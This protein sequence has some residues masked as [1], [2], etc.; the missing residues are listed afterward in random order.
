MQ[1]PTEIRNW[2]SLNAVASIVIGNDG[3]TLCQCV[4]FRPDVWLKITAGG[5]ESAATVAASPRVT[6][7]ELSV[8]STGTL[9]PAHE[10]TPVDFERL[11]LI[12]ISVFWSVLGSEM[13]EGSNATAMW[14]R[15]TFGLPLYG[16]MT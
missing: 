10:P 3:V 6:R 16:Y 13:P 8:M 4:T 1:E 9:Q 11:R 12:S 2:G 5:R 7:I 15:S 14:I